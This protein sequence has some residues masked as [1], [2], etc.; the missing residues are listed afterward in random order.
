MA[1]QVK[2]AVT[3]AAPKKTATVSGPSTQAINTAIAAAQ[4]AQPHAEYIYVNEKGEYHLH[5][6]VGFL[7]IDMADGEAIF[8]KERAPKAIKLSNVTPVVDND[9]ETETDEDV[10]A[11]NDGKEF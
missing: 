3:I 5:P 9:A 4:I 6:R 7:K 2:Q 8:Q 11:P 10:K 1:K